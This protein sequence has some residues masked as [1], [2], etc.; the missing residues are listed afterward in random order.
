VALAN[1]RESVDDLDVRRTIETDEPIE[2]IKRKP[3]KPKG[4]V[5]MKA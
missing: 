3:G 5:D 2:S 1:A 4:S